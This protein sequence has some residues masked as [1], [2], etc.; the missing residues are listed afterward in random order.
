MKSRVIAWAILL[1]GTVWSRYDFLDNV[2]YNIDEA[3][4]AVA[5]DAL[6]VGWLPGADLVGSTKPPGISGLYALIFDISGRSM[7]AVHITAAAITIGSGVLLVE[8]AILLFSL[9]A[10]IPCAILF[11]VLSHTIGPP[12]ESLALNV[13]SPQMFLVL[14]SLL[15]VAKS[16]SGWWIILAGSLLG[17]ATMFRQS[18]L[19][20]LLPAALK[21]GRSRLPRLLAGFFLPWTLL[22]SFYAARGDLGWAWDSWARYPLVY[23]SDLGIG[24]TLSALILNAVDFLRTSWPALL[25]CFGG[26]IWLYRERK[27]DSNAWVLI[28]F[29]VSFL[30]VSSGSRFY[31]HYWIQLFPV[32][33][34]AGSF[35]VMRFG[36]LGRWHF[37]GAVVILSV[38]AYTGATH[39]PHW[40][41]RNPRFPPAGMSEFSLGPQAQEYGIAE[42]VRGRTAP[43][44]CIVVW[45]YCPQIYFLSNRLPGV[46]DYLCHYITGWSTSAFDPWT[47]RAP[48]AESH[49]EAEEMFVSDLRDR[50][51]ELIVDLVRITDYPF[52]FVQYSINRY[53]RLTDYIKANYTPADK[54]GDAFIYARIKT[55]GDTPGQPE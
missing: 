30:A 37:A 51:P 17:A 26:A 21:S 5:A 18:A 16:R 19:L 3:E 39:F 48:R 10:A 54:V 27:R 7:T 24:G 33:A 14:A 41:E 8:I 38:A 50:Q 53:S 2:I 44:D 55:A 28:L 35:A 40:H 42:Y 45:G 29:G 9:A 1:V 52:T 22:L 6:K 36:R 34:L 46:R 23:A 4:Y 47:S 13:E 11:W 31:G 12:S 25:A 43:S 20:F 32:L 49:R 15:T